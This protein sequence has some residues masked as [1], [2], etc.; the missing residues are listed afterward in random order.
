MLADVA[1][2][3][4]P[5][6]DEARLLDALRAQLDHAARG[7]VDGLP[8]DLLPLRVPKDR[9]TKV[10]TC[11][12]HLLATLEHGDLTE[13]I[14]RGRVLDRLLHHHVHGG[15][16]ATRQPALALAE[17]AFEAER[18]DDLTQWLGDNLDARERLASEADAFAERLRVLGAVPSD[19]WPR[20]EDRIRVDL[21]DGDVVCA[22]QLDLVAG[23]APTPH[24]LVVLEAKSGRFGPDHRD[25]LFWYALVLALR[26]GRA[27]AAAIAWSAW[28]GATWC[29][30]I[31]EG[32]LRAATDRACVAL[33][34]LGELVR[35]RTPTATAC[36]ACAWCPVRETCGARAEVDADDC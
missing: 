4:R 27:P 6:P 2:S 22:A 28:D 32:V 33:A 8:H 21:A 31:T 26:H 7:A 25:G 34:R 1:A 12:R 36:R 29:Q 14:V 18:D 13:P 15:A 20:C 11:E 5:I 30:P 16:T 10:L 23:G 17:G 24:P 35:G 3:P 9:L 19:W